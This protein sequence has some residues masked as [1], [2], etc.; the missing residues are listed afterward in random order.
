MRALSAATVFVAVAGYLIVLLAAQAL[1]PAAYQAFLVFWGLFF[2]LTGVLEGLMQETTRAVTAQRSRSWGDG[3]PPG[4]AHPLRITTAIA[5]TSAVLCLGTSPWW[6]SHL[7]PALPTAS[8]I[9]LAVGLASFA[10]QATVGG[11]LSA[12]TRWRAFSWLIAVDSGVRLLL[13]AIAWL[14]G[15]QL[16]AFLLVTVLGAATWLGA[17]ALSPRARALLGE[18]ADVPT[19]AFLVRT[20]KAMLASGANAVLITGFPVLLAATAPPTD[21]AALTA[22]VLTAVMLTRAPLLVPL[23]RFQPA[24]IVHFTRHRRHVLRAATAPTLAVLGLAAVGAPLAYLVGQPIMTL[25]FPAYGPLVSPGVLAALTVASGS[26]ALLMITGSA[27]L[28]AERHSLYSAGWLVATAVAL[29]LLCLDWPV[30]VR[31]GVA[32]GVAPLVGAAVHLAPVAARGPQR[33]LST[34]RVA[35]ATRQG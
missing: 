30:P 17:L 2:T 19:G 21:N 35:A 13:A 32:L 18:V 20:L 12:D 28:S 5:A 11:L 23:Q 31:V 9:L 26:T 3:A 6:S 16:L 27:A 4:A 15:W 10:F 7:V 25:L 8:A 33:A 14:L 1:T 24:I 34:R 29:G 22:A